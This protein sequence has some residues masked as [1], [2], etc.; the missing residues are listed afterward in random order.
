MSQH[1]LPLPD[2]TTPERLLTELADVEVATEELRVAQEE[3]RTQQEQITQLLLQHETERRWRGQLSALVPVGLCVT[4]GAGALL[5]VNPAMATRLGTPLQRVHGKP[6]SVYLA[7][8]DVKAFRSALRTLGTGTATEHDLAVTLH[9]RRQPAVP[10]RLFGFTE[11]VDELAAGVRIQWVVVADDGTEPQAA[12]EPEPLR[13]PAVIGLA[14]A[15]AELSGM[16]VGEVDRQRLL[17]RMATL[18]SGAVPGADWV[19]ITLGHPLEPQRLGSDSTEAQEFD[20]LQVRAG[21][22]PCWQAY[23]TGEVVVSD[24]VTA[25]ARWPALA[26]IAGESAVRS[27]LALPVPGEDGVIG[28][29]NVY[30]GRPEG[31]APAG[32]RVAELVTAAVAG[33]L[34]TVAEREAMR[35]LTEHL[36]RALTSR[37][38][39]DQ[40][41]GVLMARLGVDAD[42]AFAR[43]VKVSSRLNVK[44]RDL[45]ALVVGGHADEVL[46]VAE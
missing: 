26:R 12:A 23:D 38:V 9:P 16:P 19:S 41:K 2:G 4:D 24:D 7:P 11:A 3:M 34:R 20:G 13:S 25:D 10:V 46:R 15:L 29:V 6:L 30:S 18:L 44:V 1:G 32:R 21:E 8:E 43:L 14:T 17:S 37:A 31:F 5:E 40:A 28:G 35:S 22:G 45:A 27:V 33:V 42:E 39:I 36:E